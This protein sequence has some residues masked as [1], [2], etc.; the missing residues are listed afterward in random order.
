MPEASHIDRVIRRA[1]GL[2][3]GL[4]RAAL[5]TGCRQDELVSLERRQIDHQRKQLTL[6]KTKTSRPRVLDLSSAAYDCLTSLPVQV[7][8]RNVFWHGDGLAYANVSSRFRVFVKA[9][10]KSAQSEGEDFRAFRFH[11]LR[12]K[13]AVD[14]LKNQEGSIYDLQKHLGHSSVKTTEIYLAYLTPDEERAAKSGTAQST[15]HVQRLSTD[16]RRQGVED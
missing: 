7:A 15:A 12:H 9:A 13:F 16:T 14:Y 11:D 10:Q 2:F 3:A 6:Y 5:L 1:P 4:I 8:T